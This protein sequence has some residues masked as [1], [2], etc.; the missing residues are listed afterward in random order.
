M[1]VRLSSALKVLNGFRKFN[2]LKAMHNKP[3][4]NGED[5]SLV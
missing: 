5:L 2:T 1:K 3:L 4:Y